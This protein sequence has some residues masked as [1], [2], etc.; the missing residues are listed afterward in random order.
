MQILL[1]R[2]ITLS[3]PRITPQHAKKLL[4][5]CFLKP[6]KI[7]NPSLESFLNKLNPL[8]T[9]QKLSEGSFV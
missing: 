3:L 5:A 7:T 4:L 1:Q 9:L 2:S 6:Q 8:I